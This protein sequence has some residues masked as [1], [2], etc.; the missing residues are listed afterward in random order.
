M[1]TNDEPGTD[2]RR[3]LLVVLAAVLLPSALMLI[4]STSHPELGYVLIVLAFPAAWA[5]RERRDRRTREGTDERAQ[6]IHWRATSFSWRVVIVALAAAATWADLRHGVRSTEP[7]LALTAVAL[8]SYL[9][10]VLWR[11]WRGF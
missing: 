7:Y 5:V 4:S 1:L 11:R 8:G 2:R 9:T 10:A 3:I 6:E